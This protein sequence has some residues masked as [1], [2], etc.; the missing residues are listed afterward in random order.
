[1][2]R[3]AR[4]KTL[5][6]VAHHEAGHAVA[7]I[8]LGIP[9]QYATVLAEEDS[10][11]HVLFKRAPKWACN[12]YSPRRLRQREYWEHKV[13]V[14]FAGRIAEEHFLGRGT[15][16]GHHSDYQNIVDC[17]LPFWGANP[18]VHIHW[19]RWLHAQSKELVIRRWRDISAVANALIESETL[20][21]QEIRNL[22]NK[23]YG[24]LPAFDR[25]HG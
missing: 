7:A 21:Y 10:L 22:V 11:G 18:E 14:G 25:L 23:L 3:T 6:T 17:G 8:Y 1:M 19:F 16:Y 4:K 2:A 24:P 13:I 9:F 5:L 20:S 12:E 15:R